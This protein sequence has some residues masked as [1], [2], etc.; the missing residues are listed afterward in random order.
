[1]DKG[2]AGDYFVED[3]DDLVDG[4][5]AQYGEHSLTTEVNK[6]RQL[7]LQLTDDNYY[8]ESAFQ[9]G[10]W[11]SPSWNFEV[12]GLGEAFVRVGFEIG[13]AMEARTV[14]AFESEPEVYLRSPL[15]S[16][17]QMRG[18]VVPVDTDDVLDMKPG[19]SFALNGRGALGLNVGAGV[20]FVIADPGAFTYQIV[21][22]AALR[23]YLEGDLDVQLVRVG[24]NDVV[25]DVG[26]SKVNGYKAEL[27]VKDGWGVSGLFEAKVSLGPVDVDLGKIADKALRSQ[28][29]KYVTAL[30]GEISRT[31]KTTRMSVARF[32][33]T[34]EPGNTEGVV[35]E[36][37][38]QA[39]RGD[40]RAAQNLSNR[41]Y[42]GVESQF[43]LFRTG[44]SLSHHA[45][46]DVLG[47]S[48]VYHRT[49]Q[50]GSIVVQTPEGSGAYLFETL[51]KESGWF[52][53]THGDQRVG[54]AGL[55]INNQG[56]FKSEVNLP[57]QVVE[58]DTQM[59]KDKLL[60]HY[61][62]LLLALGGPEAVAAIAG[63]GNEM[64]RFTYANCD[65][66]NGYAECRETIVLDP[67]VTSRKSSALR[68]LVGAISDL[69]KNQRDVIHYIAEQRLNASAV[70]EGVGTFKGPSV[71]LVNSF[72][73]DEA[74]LEH[75]MTKVEGEDAM[76]AAIEYLKLVRID[77]RDDPSKIESVQED[78]EDDY[79]DEL[80]EFAE[81]WDRYAGKY[82]G[83]LEVEREMRE[84]LGELAAYAVE[85][86]L[87]VS[88]DEAPAWEEFAADSMTVARMRVATRLY[89][90]LKD[91]AEG[92]RS[93]HVALYTL[94]SLAPESHRD[95]AVDVK[96]Q[97][98]GDIDDAYR[99]AEWVPFLQ[100][101]KGA[102][103]A[104]IKAP[105]FNL[106]LLRNI[107]NDLTERGW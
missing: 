96:M 49:E 50:D 73:L 5:V 58:G 64:D 60:H 76:R 2:L 13:A 72:R 94:M 83:Y 24:G 107:N 100:R 55:S 67:Y 71:S 89:D 20:P 29:N 90:K 42:P 32:R 41:G 81:K 39:A 91:K 26:M 10:L 104:R 36:A 6:I 46:I 88:K 33:F 74:A 54:L 101:L 11:F 22:S 77:R 31:K 12:S 30:D 87:P 43:D 40:I 98:G 28:L 18:F 45:G 9:A 56:E 69:P 75:L 95:L 37:L 57:L 3:I 84:A 1:L 62:G 99:A 79:Q 106:D 105:M 103:A 16:A 7:H 63:P 92:H 35:A 59:E 78:I 19:E 70:R 44:Q 17:R 15:A 80:E 27:A 68:A 23:T 4:L 48:F 66:S 102:D 97:L 53:T 86:R 82:Q 8:G 52:F 21:F 47:M 93:S 34:L 14:T 51:H 38:A 65:G 25:V 85:V 61:D